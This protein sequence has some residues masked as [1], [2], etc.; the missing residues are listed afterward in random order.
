MEQRVEKV[1]HASLERLQMDKKLR[2]AINERAD[3]LLVGRTKAG[4]AQELSPWDVHH[5]ARLQTMQF[6]H[7]RSG[8][9][10]RL[11]SIAATSLPMFTVEH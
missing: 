2:P 8:R 6:E 4:L 11:S 7:E 3:Q 10:V 9:I 5:N 1:R